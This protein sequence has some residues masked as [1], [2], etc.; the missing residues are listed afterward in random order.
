MVKVPKDPF[1]TEVP[2]DATIVA[3]EWKNELEGVDPAGPA[4][5]VWSND[6]RTPYEYHEDGTAR[7]VRLSQISYRDVPV[8]EV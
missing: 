7:W 5:F 8:N 4:W 2:Q 6:A 3:I 1:T